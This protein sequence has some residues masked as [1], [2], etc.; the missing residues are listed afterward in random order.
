MRIAEVAKDVSAALDQLE[1]A[2]VHDGRSLLRRANRVRTRSISAF[3]VLIPV[4]DFFWNA[5]ITHKCP[6]ISVT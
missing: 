1:F 4:F 3:G 5:W 2:V 6:I